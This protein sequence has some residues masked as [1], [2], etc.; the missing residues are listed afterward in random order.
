MNK[1][2]N[3]YANADGTP[4]KGLEFQFLDWSIEQDRNRINSLPKKE[5]SKELDSRKRLRDKMES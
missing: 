3:P 2:N 4:K 1:Q 5:R